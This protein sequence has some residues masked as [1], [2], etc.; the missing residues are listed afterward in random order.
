MKENY[1]RCAADLDTLSKLIEE[2][3]PDLL[4]NGSGYALLFRFLTFEAIPVMEVRH[5]NLANKLANVYGYTGTVQVDRG[6][7][8]EPS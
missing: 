6:I 1:E 3:Y 8:D 2:D 4:N 7:G 5:L